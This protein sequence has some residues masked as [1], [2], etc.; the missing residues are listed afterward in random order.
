MKEILDVAGTV[1]GI[2]GIAITA[3]IIIFKSVI[4][5]FLTQH[6]PKLNREQVFHLLNKILN[7]TFFIAVLG[8]LS[9]SLGKYLERPLSNK[10]TDTPTLGS[11]IDASSEDDEISVQSLKTNTSGLTLPVSVPQKDL[12]EYT[13]FMEVPVEYG[14][15]TGLK[16]YEQK[17]KLKFE[18]DG[19]PN[20]AA[21]AFLIAMQL[22]EIAWD[23]KKNRLIT[24]QRIAELRDSLDEINKEESTKAQAIIDSLQSN[25]TATTKGRE[26]QLIA[27]FGKDRSVNNPVDTSHET[28]V[29]TN[30][31]TK[32]RNDWY[33][34]T[35][36]RFSQIF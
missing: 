26:Y 6:S 9:W 28:S 19:N 31:S 17:W 13:N 33:W 36:L 15:I 32:Y 22:A 4:A 11:S 18:K 29:L 12:T 5:E 27:L 30:F 21:K 35:R 10:S 7:F 24:D 8:V 16:V 2:G 20:E 34:K 1:A 23:E 3:G 25:I 14:D